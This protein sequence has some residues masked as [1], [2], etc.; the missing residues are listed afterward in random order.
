[1]RPKTKI[2]ILAAALL[3]FFSFLIFKSVQSSLVYYL[4][5]SEVRERESF[6]K[7]KRLRVSGIV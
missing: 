4:T 7:F 5:V 1:M 3:I 6:S 2:K